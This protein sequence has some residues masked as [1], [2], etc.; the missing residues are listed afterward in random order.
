MSLH[1]QN[2]EPTKQVLWVVLC[3]FHYVF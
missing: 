2:V 1:D 3:T